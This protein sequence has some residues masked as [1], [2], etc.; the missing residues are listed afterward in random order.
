[1][2][3]RIVDLSKAAAAEIDSVV[4]GVVSVTLT[5]VTVGDNS[6]RKASSAGDDRPATAWAVQAG[7]FSAEENAA[8]LR[9]RLAERYPT[10][11]TEEFAGLKRVKF[12]PYRSKSEAEAARDS[13][14]DLGLAGI[15]VPYR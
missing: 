3:G 6:R 1:V 14:A 7:A 12:G 5:V 11:W 8:R 13:L 9:D 2:A 4:D 10:P 15:V